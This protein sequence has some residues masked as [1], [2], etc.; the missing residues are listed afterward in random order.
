[1]KLVAPGM[2]DLLHTYS[3]HVGSK[4]C[5]MVGIKIL[6]RVSYCMYELCH[7]SV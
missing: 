3:A 7:W 1:M 5:D 4:G 6:I 2:F